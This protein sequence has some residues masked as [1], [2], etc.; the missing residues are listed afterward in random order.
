[1]PRAE[2]LLANRVPEL[3]ALGDR[4]VRSLASDSR[5]VTPG[6]LFFAVPGWQSDGNA[7]AEAAVRGGAIAVVSEAEPRELGVPWLRV[8]DVH[9]VLAAAC[10][11]FF[12]R[13][14]SAMRYAGVTGTNGK[15][16]IT[17]LF[18]AM[19]CA[20]GAR[21]GLLG[22]IEQRFEA[23]R[24]PATHTTL[25]PIALCSR[26]QEMETLGA[27]WAVLEVS[28]HALAQKRADALRFSVSAF[29]NL[30]PD[31]LDYH[32]TMDAYF[33][34]KARL[35][36]E[37]TTGVSVI[38]TGGAGGERMLA[39][40]RGEKLTVARD[41]GDVCVKRAVVERDRTPLVLHTPSGPL[42]LVSPLIGDFNI[43]NVLVAVGMAIAAGIS[44]DAIATGIAGV[45]VPGRLQAVRAADGRL[46]FVDY[47]HTP[48]ALARTLA[49]LQALPH[50]RVLCV[51]G[52]GG[53]RDR[54]KR[55]LMGEAVAAHSDVAVVTSDNPRGEAAQAIIA[56]ILPGLRAFA[57]RSP[58]QEIA[59]HSFVVLADRGEAIRWAAEKTRAT[60]LL[61]VAGK[62]HETYQIVGDER[63]HFDD[64][65]VLQAAFGGVA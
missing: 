17:F 11:V 47:A 15:T 63:R 41:R 48:D 8:R 55:P 30:T 4:E 37:L 56:D 62:G 29:S 53:D 32:G 51:F 26:L 18:E 59:S 10:R 50:D 57:E 25:L 24:W 20:A 16:T 35:F 28:S 40:V 23:K 31:H 52:C 44:L 61:L 39:E 34:A 13:D 42:E 65:E 5:A 54:S 46:A 58:E 49:T 6:A 2:T 9:G 7:H 21:I 43:E 19:A 22:T 33:A 60:D 45:Q 36:R 14:T 1:M 38:H 12:A 64:R 3:S 27:E